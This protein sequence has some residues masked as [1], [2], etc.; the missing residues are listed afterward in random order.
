MIDETK[1]LIDICSLIKELFSFSAGLIAVLVV[2]YWCLV[3]RA[4]S[5]L[6]GEIVFWPP[7]ITMSNNYI[8]SPSG[9]AIPVVASIQL[10]FLNARILPLPEI[11][12]DLT[13]VLDIPGHAPV[14]YAPY[15]FMKEGVFEKVGNQWKPL[16]DERFHSFLIPPR[17]TITKNILFLPAAGKENKLNDLPQ[18][19]IKYMM[20]IKKLYQFDRKVGPYP[21]IVDDPN[22][23]TLN[24]P[25]HNWGP[26]D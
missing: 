15:M 25:I 18:G 8:H 11:I 1:S 10:S 12:K 9:K 24:E 6:I 17:D 23:L 22:F 2:G 7:Q 16:Q 19:T 4:T 20:I 14:K 13:L 3:S 5:W 26:Q 21:I